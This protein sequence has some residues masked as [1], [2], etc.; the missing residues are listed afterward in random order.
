M[1]APKFLKLAL[2]GSLISVLAACGG[3]SD[4]F[5]SDANAQSGFISAY[6]SGLETLGSLAGLASSSFRELFDA[7]YADSG[8]TR[9]AVVSHIGEPWPCP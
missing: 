4:D 3:G 7:G 8:M 9:A 6:T 2:A 1:N 5:T